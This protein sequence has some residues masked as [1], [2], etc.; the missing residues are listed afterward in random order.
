M[1]E[2]IYL[3]RDPSTG[4]FF[5]GNAEWTKKSAEAMQFPDSRA[6]VSECERQCLDRYQILSKE[7]PEASVGT[8]VLEHPSH[9]RSHF[10]NTRSAA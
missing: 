7:K 6:A 9:D 2:L 8:I 3:I 1:A 5:C 4:K 10:F